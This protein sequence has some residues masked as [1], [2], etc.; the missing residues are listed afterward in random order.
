VRRYAQRKGLVAM[1][2]VALTAFAREEDRRRAHEAGFDAH[3][4]KP[5]Q[6]HALVAAVLSVVRPRAGAN[7][8]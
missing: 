6:P 4:T 7:P 3:L 1:P 2:A 5:L 8:H